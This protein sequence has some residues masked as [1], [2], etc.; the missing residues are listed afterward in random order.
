MYE[1]M[2]ILLTIFLTFIPS[3]FSSYP[4]DLDDDPFI[5][6]DA[7][8]ETN[9][10]HGHITRK[11]HHHHHH[12]HHHGY[13]PT[14]SPQVFNVHTFGAKA[15][16]KDDSKAFKEAWEAGCSSTGIVYIVVPK[17]RSYILKPVKFSGPCISSLIV[18]KIYGKLEAWKNPLDYKESKHWIV[19]KNVSNLRVEGGGRIDGNGDIWWPKSCKINPKLPCVG[20]PTAVTFVEC[21][22]L[23]VS[24]I[25]LQNAQQMHL[26]FQDCKNVKALKLMVTS[27]SDSPNTDGIHVTGTRNIII[28]DSIIRTGDDCISIVSGS[29]NVRATG[30]TC[31]P[32]HGISIG[33][34]GKNNSEGYVSNV[35]VNK[36]TLI[37]TTN[38]VRIKTWQGGHGVVENVIFQ[39]IIMKNV[40]NP[41]IINQNYC[42][43]VESCPEQESAVQ[44]NNVLY[45]NIQGTSSRPIAVKFECSKSIPC[46]GILMHNVELVEQSTH[47]QHHVS[48]AFCSNVF[49]DTR[50][51]VSPLCNW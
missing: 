26:R 49:L 6:S 17:H 42:D 22:N 10:L 16:G 40:T 29:E 8:H 46:Q 21:M 9:H 37:G 41:I 3:C 36:S 15:N 2:I 23:K 50:G 12:H 11:S 28:K 13:A 51:S 4:L 30:I 47:Q 34:L 31:G 7:F 48:K 24:N 38:G 1:N 5:F 20:A 27:P 18:F 35:L 14:S 25:R 32:G 45:K 39:D 43:R 33:S 44:V 19:F